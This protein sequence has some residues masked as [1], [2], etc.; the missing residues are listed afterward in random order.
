MDLD[1][2]LEA[3]RLFDR[4]EAAGRGALHFST[5]AGAIQSTQNKPKV[6]DLPREFQGGGGETKG[7]KG[8]TGIRI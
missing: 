1:T 8:R 7:S 6:G 4:W 2:T 5:R 3:G